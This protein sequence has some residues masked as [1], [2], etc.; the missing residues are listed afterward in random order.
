MM[1]PG[2]IS[3]KAEIDP[4]AKIGKN[5]TIYPFA[6]IEGDVEIGDNCVIFPNVSILDGTRMGKD[7]KIHQGTV[8]AAL[9]QD[10]HF[11]GDPSTVIIGD[12]NIIRENV[13][14]NRA[15]FSD[16]KTVIGSHNCFMEGAHVS[17]DAKI[18]DNNVLGYGTK[19]AGDCEIEDYVI[20]SSSVIVNA[21]ARVG[22]GSMLSGGCRVSRD[23]PPYI[24]ATDNPV[25]YGGINSTILTLHNVSE[26]TQGHIANAYRL[27][28]HGQTS[29]FDSVIQVKE[30]VPDGKEVQHLIEFI[31]ATKLGII[32]KD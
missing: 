23:V 21:G 17:H 15:T 5:V 28:F 22:R 8:I 3:P 16:G 7:N 32:S 4:K 6:Y 29:V 31:K 10:F 25:K 11:K 13:V 20:F 30:Q 18:G 26:K 2:T 27:I 1:I 19:I 9:P 14:I 12:G 24:I